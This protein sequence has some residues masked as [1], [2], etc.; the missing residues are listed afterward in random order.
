M[1]PGI[2][3]EYLPLFAKAALVT[4]KISA[5]GILISFAVGLICSGVQYFRIPVLKQI[6]KMQ[7]Q[8]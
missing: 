5:I 1:N 8:E 7:L 2:L 6:A 4:L 3:L